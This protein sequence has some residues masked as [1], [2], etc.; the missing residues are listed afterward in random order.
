MSSPPLLAKR[1]KRYK[2]LAGQF[3]SVQRSVL[4]LLTGLMR[5]SV[6]APQTGQALGTS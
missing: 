6:A 4:T 3:G 1:T 2:C 5:T